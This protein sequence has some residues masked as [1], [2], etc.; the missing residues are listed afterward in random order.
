MSNDGT[1]GQPGQPQ[2]DATNGEWVSGPYRWDE[3]SQQW[4]PRQ[5]SA[6]AAAAPAS[7]TSP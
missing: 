2:W 4:L 1:P 3:Q 5:A 6:P 7:C